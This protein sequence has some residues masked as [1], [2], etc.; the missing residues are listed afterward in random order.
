MAIE[1]LPVWTFE[2]NWTNSVTETFEWN[3]RIRTSAS[4]AEQ[5]DAI[6][7]YPWITYEFTA[8]AEGIARQYL[9]QMLIT[10]GTTEWYLPL[11]H[12]AAIVDADAPA[13][14][15]VISGPDF[16]TLEW[17]RVGTVACILNGNPRTYELVEIS[18]RTS[19]SI[20]LATST[21][22]AWPAGSMVFPC[23]IAELTD[24][25]EV[26]H[27]TS[28]MATAEIRFRLSRLQVF[29]YA[30]DPILENTMV[31]GQFQGQQVFD[32]EPDWTEAPR[33]GYDR[34]T[35]ELSNGRGFPLRKDEAGRAFTTIR[36]Q[37]TLQGRAE[38][39]SF[40]R[41]L[42]YLRGRARPVWVPT[43]TDDLI[44]AADV[45]SGAAS[46][47]V[48][49]NGYF[50]LGGPRDDR[51]WIMI[52]LDTGARILREVTA[53]GNAGLNH[54]LTL[55]PVITTSFGVERVVR[56]SFLILCRL[57]HDGVSVEHKTDTLGVSAVQMTFRSAPN[58]RN[59]PEAFG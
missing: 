42:Q 56:I 18:E 16:V 44:L 19:N 27:R 35:V 30:I 59:T 32:F 38:H 13:G 55:S 54:T 3:T 4:G 36:S 10:N 11:F 17:A 12:E 58:S 53:V 41:T 22:R 24:Q 29:P 15:M 7:A 8:V 46:I 34:T 51:R 5:R 21:T 39:V 20:T 1:N 33:I 52:E 6:R 9:D 26:I 37:W 48:N 14:T 31:S 23:V 43:F 45:A 25:P 50:G 2:P 28:S 49:A 47:T 57:N 40:L